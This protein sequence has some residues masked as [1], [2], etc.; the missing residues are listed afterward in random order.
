MFLF[1]HLFLHHLL[2]IRLVQ[3]IGRQQVEI[4]LLPSVKHNHKLAHLV[5]DVRVF[6]VSTLLLIALHNRKHLQI[7]WGA[8]MNMMVD[9]MQ[10]NRPWHV[11][12][13][14]GQRQLLSL[15]IIFEI[16]CLKGE[17]IYK[18]FAHFLTI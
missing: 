4:L 17:E 1:L 13:T 18:I 15:L 16:L 8:L 12:F 14:L 10:P 5:I 9:P 7:L 3:I 2:C 11:K 6:D